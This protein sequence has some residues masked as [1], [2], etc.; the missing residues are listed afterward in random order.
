MQMSAGR[1]L[2]QQYNKS[3]IIMHE[4][5]VGVTVTSFYMT[6]ERRQIQCEYQR[7]KRQRNR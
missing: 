7:W 2:C 3:I 6:E 5:V 4:I 1:W